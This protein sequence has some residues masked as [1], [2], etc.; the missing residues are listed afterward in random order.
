M[1]TSIL[2]HC[3]QGWADPRVSMR[4]L[5]TCPLCKASFDRIIR[6]EAA[7]TSDQKIYSQTIPCTSS[8]DVFL[9]EDQGTHRFD[10]EVTFILV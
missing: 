6:V 9:L 7:D 4:K 8:T 3:I 1:R 10:A 5:S 2:L